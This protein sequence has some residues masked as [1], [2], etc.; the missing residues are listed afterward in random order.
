MPIVVKSS[1]DQTLVEIYTCPAPAADVLYVGENLG[2][3]AGVYESTDQEASPRVHKFKSLVEGTGISITEDATEITISG[4]N[5][6]AVANVGTGAEVHRDTTSDVAHLRSVVAGTGIRVEQ[7]AD[8]IKISATSGSLGVFDLSTIAHADLICGTTQTIYPY[9]SLANLAV[10]DLMVWTMVVVPGNWVG[11]NACMQLPTGWLPYITPKYLANDYW[12]MHTAVAYRFATADDLL[13]GTSYTVTMLRTGGN[14]CGRVTAYRGANENSPL[15]AM[16]AAYRRSNDDITALPVPGETVDQPVISQYLIFDDNPQ[17]PA[18]PTTSK[19]VGTVDTYMDFHQLLTGFA[20]QNTRIA[21]STL[22]VKD[23]EN[24]IPGENYNASLGAAGWIS[25]GISART[26]SGRFTVFSALTTNTRHYIERLVDLVAGEQYT[27]HFA[28]TRSGWNSSAPNMNMGISYI[29]PSDVE[30]GFKNLDTG[31]GAKLDPLA[32][33]GTVWE[34]RIYPV[35]SSGVPSRLGSISTIYINAQTTGT[36][37]IRISA[38]D[39]AGNWTFLG[40]GN[41]GY[42]VTSVGFRSKWRFPTQ[43]YTDATSISA[44]SAMRMLQVPGWLGVSGVAGA[45]EGLITK[46]FPVVPAGTLSAVKAFPYAQVPYNNQYLNALLKGDRV[47]TAWGSGLGDSP[48]STFGPTMPIYPVYAGARR[49]YYFEFVSLAA[50]NRWSIWTGPVG[51]PTTIIGYNNKPGYFWSGPDNYISNPIAADGS[52]AAGV[53]TLAINDVLGVAHDFSSGN[54][55]VTTFYKNGLIVKSFTVTQDAATTQWH[56]DEPWTMWA[57][58]GY[59]SG[60]SGT[61][62]FRLNFGGDST[63]AYK[64]IGYEPWDIGYIPSTPAPSQAGDLVVGTGNGTSEILAVGLDGQTLVADSEYQTG[65]K[66]VDRPPVLRGAAFVSTAGL[67]PAVPLVALHMAK[68]C[69]I[70]RIVVVGDTVG[71]AEIAIGSTTYAAYTGAMGANI[72]GS[73]PP[74]ITSSAGLDKTSFTGWDL[75]VSANDILTVKLNSVSGFSRLNVIIYFG[76]A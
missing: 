30:R 58:T 16:T 75:V 2:T 8:E 64:P 55:C 25:S 7:L 38:L 56:P 47:T 6:F 15:G 68:A 24:W 22:S 62:L 17:A 29:D 65:M 20:T 36:H 71:S 19:P 59:F 13:P 57:M 32:D 45:T 70:E 66:W 23:D 39:T 53:S 4:A 26:R 46:A 14:V 73:D 72:C 21:S 74:T 63:F 60:G 76:D 50:S 42:A 49:K 67:T 5:Q 52:L 28:N 54:S 34:G 1:C 51:A 37:K 61:S 43:V 69:V 41:E 18:F 27:F 31:M 35:P 44:G 48:P 3:G 10:G 33:H 12:E 9:A 11:T 40:A